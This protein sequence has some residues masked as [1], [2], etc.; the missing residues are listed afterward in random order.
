MISFGFL[1]VTNNR[2]IA[3]NMLQNHFKVEIGSH[4]TIKVDFCVKTFFL[5]CQVD[6][7]R[8]QNGYVYA[9]TKN[10]ANNKFYNH[11]KV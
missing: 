7:N 6:K 4:A 1:K 5:S 9:Y 10:N 11:F 3:N 8:T 2:N